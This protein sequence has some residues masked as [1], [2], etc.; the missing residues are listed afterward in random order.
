MGYF[1]LPEHTCFLLVLENLSFHIILET[2]TVI[3]K[4][5]ITHILYMCLYI[6][7]RKIIIP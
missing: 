3:Q 4:E 6:L 1:I 2:D 7:T 5:Y